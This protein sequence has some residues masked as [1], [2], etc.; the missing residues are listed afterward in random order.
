MTTNCTS[1][2]NTWRCYPYYTY[3]DNPTGVAT[4]F[5]WVINQT[6]GKDFAISTTA[7]MF[8]FSFDNVPLSL[9]DKGQ[10]SERYHFSTMVNAVIAPIGQLTPD[11]AKALC[12]YNSTTFQADLYTK[13]AK[14]YPNS[15]SVG[16]VPSTPPGSSTA[17]QAWPYALSVELSISGGPDVP[18]C[19]TIVNSLPGGLI[20]NGFTAESS[21]SKCSCFYQNADTAPF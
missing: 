17:F 6:N 18:A 15:T 16:A 14:L 12:Y 21:S 8:S 19:Y 7:N 3:Q 2:P 1:N 4:Q 13:M 11:N 20:T 10:A 9:V 5:Q